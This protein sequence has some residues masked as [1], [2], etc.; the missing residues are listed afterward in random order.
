M[1]FRTTFSN[2]QS[3]GLAILSG[4]LLA[5]SFPPLGLAPGFLAFFALVPLLLSIEN[6]DRWLG[7][8][9]RAFVAMF[10]FGV[11]ANYW[12]GGWKGEG[13]VDPFLMLGGVLLAL[14][15]PFFLVIPWVLYDGIRRRFSRR[16][17]LVSLPILYTG[18][19]YWHSFGDLSYPWLSMFNT[20]T[21]NTAYIQFIEFTGSY[22]LTTVIVTVNCLIYGLLKRRES[23][24]AAWKYGMAIALL[25]LLPYAYGLYAL[26]TSE[27]T[28]GNVRISIV[29]PSIN[30]WAKWES[31]NEQIMKINYETSIDALKSVHDSTDLL[32]WPETAITFPITL[33]EYSYDL[34][35]FSGFLRYT[36]KAVLTGFPDMERY[37]VG[38]DTIPEDAKPT[39]S[40]NVMLRSW[41]ASML[42]YADEKGNVRFQRYHKQKLVPLGEHVPFV[43]MFPVLGKIFKWGVGLG[44]WNMG[45]GYGVFHLPL[46][47]GDSLAGNARMDTARIWTMICYESVYP[48]FV[49]KFVSNGANV[50]SIITNDGWYG[51]SFGP[52]QHNQFAVLRAIENRRCIA[53]CA[54]TGISS[55]I[56]DRGRFVEQ[57]PL[58]VRTSL[59]KE[60]PLIERK[61]LYT[62]FG[63]FVAIPSLVYTA[64]AFLYLVGLKLR[65]RYGRKRDVAVKPIASV[66][67]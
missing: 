50:L 26:N 3:Y 56:D 63:D 37:E 60:L 17:A 28:R 57:S 18:F 53:R 43:D 9:R 31:A 35:E 20:Q 48:S 25:F 32:L 7:A 5:L 58:F 12:V 14:V 21:Y 65:Q 40:P 13:E 24:P 8:F 2:R 10:V 39:Q 15:H 52:F 51:K 16:A 61:T 4:I 49:R 29:Q 45:Q 67:A 19:E 44:S 41:N 47:R 42:A 64:I 55:F 11:I 36:H 38:R 27:E 59:T 30:P 66:E 33:P 6:V 23:S 22:F 54:N 46:Q 34:N 1:I 62:R